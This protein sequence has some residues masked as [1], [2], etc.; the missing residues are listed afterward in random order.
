[1]RSITRNLGLVAAVAILAACGSAPSVPTKCP[2]ILPSVET[3]TRE[4]TKDVVNDGISA[5]NVTD[6]DLSAVILQLLEHIEKLRDYKDTVVRSW[7]DC[8]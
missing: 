5:D 3:P 7:K 2:A 4:E 8:P 1:M 6:A